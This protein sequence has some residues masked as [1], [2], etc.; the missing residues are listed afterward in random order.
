[1]FSVF[2]VKLVDRGT[3][4]DR[5]PFRLQKDLCMHRKVFLRPGILSILWLLTFLPMFSVIEGAIIWVDD[6]SQHD[7]GP[8]DPLVSDPAEDGS[9][10]HPFDAI[11]EAINV[12]LVGDEVVLRD[13]TYTGDGNRD[14][15]YIGKAIAV[16]SESG[17]PSTCTIDCQGNSGAPHRGFYFHSG[18]TSEAVVFGLTIANG[19]ANGSSPAGAYG[20]GI[21]CVASSPTVANCTFKD[22]KVWAAPSVGGGISCINS[23]ATIRNCRFTENK[24]IRGDSI[25]FHEGDESTVVNC[26]I[27]DDEAR[28]EIYSEDSTPTL[29]NT[30]IWSLHENS[31]YFTGTA[32]TIRYCAIRGGWPG[33]GNLNVDPLLTPDGH[34]TASSTCRDSGDPL[35]SHAGQA[36]I[37]GESRSADAGVDMGADE[38]HDIDNDGLPDW[39]EVRH[40]GNPQAGL[41]DGNDDDDQRTNLEEYAIGT[42]P[43]LAPVTYYVAPDGNDTWDGLLPTWDGAS[44]PKATIQAALNATH[45]NEGDEVILADGTYTGDGNRDI[46]YHGHAVTV[47]SASGNPETCIIDAQGSEAEPHRGFYFHSGERE[48]SRLFGVTITGGYAHSPNSSYSHGGGVYCYDGAPTIENCII[49]N[50]VA[51]NE[52][53]YGGGANG[54]EATF[55]NCVFEGNEASRGGGCYQGI[56]IDCK[57]RRNFALWGGGVMNGDL[58]GCEVAENVAVSGGGVAV[59]GN[60]RVIE[61]EIRGNRAEAQG[62]GVHCWWGDL[63]IQD[64]KILDN[65]TV[66]GAGGVHCNMHTSDLARMLRCEIVGN[67][68]EK[69]SWGVG[70]AYFQGGESIITDCRI[71]RNGCS[72][73]IS[74]WASNTTIRNCLVMDNQR[75]GAY[76]EDSNTSWINCTITGNH[77]AGILLDGG[78]STLRNCIVFDNRFAALDPHDGE[79]SVTYSNIEGGWSG[80]GNLDVDPLLTAAGRLLAGSPCRDMG[81]PNGDY[82]DLAD[83]DGEPRLHGSAVDIGADEFSDT[84]SDALPDFFELHHFGDP[85]SAAPHDNPDSDQRDNLA[86]YEAGSDPQLATVRYYV[87]P[88]GNDTWDGLSLYWNGVNGPKATIQA[89]INLTDLWE[90]DEVVLA[91]GLYVGD[92]NRDLSMHGRSTIV[93]SMNGDPERCVI[94]AQGTEEDAHR[95]FRFECGETPASQLRGLTLRG[96]YVPDVDNYYNSGGAVFIHG[97]HPFIGQCRIVDNY[98]VESGG[99]IFCLL[100]G[101]DLCNSD[102]R[103]NQSDEDGGAVYALSGSKLKV[104]RCVFSDNATGDDGGGIYLDRSEAVLRNSLFVSHDSV[105]VDAANI[106]AGHEML[107]EN[108]TIIGNRWGLSFSDY[109]TV[110]NSIIRN[111][112]LGDFFAHSDRATVTYSNI[113][114][115]WTGEGNIDEEPGFVSGGYWDDNGTPI[116]PYDDI[117]IPGNYHL[118]STSPCI[119]T[120]DPQLVP[121]VGETDL[122]GYLRVLCNRVDLGAFEFGIGDYDCN[123]AVDLADLLGWDDCMTGPGG[124][125]YPAVCAS[126]DFN[127]DSYVDLFDFAGVQR[128]VP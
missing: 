120:G 5:I 123:R 98:A 118:A 7:P 6:D 42:D 21:L 43:H 17:K 110:R 80:E 56:L 111:N 126:F 2:V 36:D 77:H 79:Y 119:N 67:K 103:E 108:C 8:G 117:W 102:L 115:G 113:G 44:G 114:G 51:A 128:T 10:E 62:G 96:G 12:A 23:A 33:E 93:R 58:R 90:G 25:S 34:L 16:R 57:I 60:C 46:D 97:S 50:C 76:A 29:T 66:N 9:A 84:D 20:G 1:M 3:G 22:N 100:G 39:W 68:S 32:P 63:D 127:A 95:V 4:S 109:L 15:D 30:V 92:G 64:C 54:G 19:Y 75:A 74:I 122:D 38:F 70:A 101:V 105:A 125:A 52:V 24:S 41:P 81:A 83:V 121:T 73:G 14:L 65:V 85:V 69:L 78:S 13:G 49:R 107:V 53:G 91:D 89:A 47:R 59:A 35:G 116:N 26:T 37:D 11:Q 71:A 86:E 72:Y 18:E 82:E 99:A 104:N 31:L 112:K 45:P 40:F 55:V 27:G 48:R 88:E 87:H 106:I 94:D 124:N 28:R 61:C